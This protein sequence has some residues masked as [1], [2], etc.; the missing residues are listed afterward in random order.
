VEI[1]TKNIMVILTM[2]VM[3]VVLVILARLPR[4]DG[5]AFGHLVLVIL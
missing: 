2:L 1:T 3:L 5:R 4:F